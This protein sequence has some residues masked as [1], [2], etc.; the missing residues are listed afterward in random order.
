MRSRF[1]LR[2][3]PRSIRMLQNMDTFNF[4]D[5][6]KLL[7]NILER[8]VK[9]GRDRKSGHPFV[10]GINKK[11]C[12]KGHKYITLV[13]EMINSGVDYISYGRKMKSLDGYY[14][15]LTEDQRVSVDMWGHFMSSTMKHVPD[16][17]SKIVFGRFHVMKHVNEA[18][19]STLRKEK[20]D[21]SEKRGD[22]SQG[23]KI[24]MALS[25]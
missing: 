25:L 14:E 6:M 10:I 23:N 22:G 4:T 18:I 15:T 24:N 21:L 7:W 1:S 2:F 5:I 11:S 12:R 3:E 19:D 17:N 8:A 16:A 9:R 13:Y 20:R